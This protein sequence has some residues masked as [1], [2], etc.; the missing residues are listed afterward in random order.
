MSTDYWPSHSEARLNELREQLEYERTHDTLTGLEN[1]IQLLERLTIT[2]EHSWRQAVLLISIDNFRTVND[3]LGHAAGDRI[4]VEIAR[5]LEEVAGPGGGVARLAGDEFA[6]FVDA[7][8]EKNLLRLAQRLLQSLRQPLPAEDHALRLAAS[9]GIC[10]PQDGATAGTYLRDADTAMHVAKSHGAGQIRIFNPRMRA[11]IVDRFEIATSLGDALGTGTGL[12]LHFQPVVDL[13]TGALVGAE[14]L[15]RWD[16]PQRGMIPPDRFIRIAEE[17]G[18]IVDLGRWVLEAAVRQLADWMPLIGDREFR[19]HVNLSPVEIRQSG[20]VED[21][22]NILTTY[23]ADPAKM[24]VEITET[25]LMTNYE[26]S[27]EA[28]RGL[29]DAGLGIGIDDFGTGYSSISYLGQLPVDTVKLDRSLI[30]GIASS[31]FEYGLARAILELMHSAGLRVI[32]EGI[33]NQAQVAH[34]RAL[35]CRYGQGFHLARPAPAEATT[36]GLERD[37]ARF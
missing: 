33:E 2:L 30:S 16:H 13:E 12:L 17:T 28:L 11:E 5:R 3:T 18:L 20:L 23:G 34:L 36:A 4:L 25:E 27:L 19:V 24:L 22:S 26:T 31:P 6:M 29:R 21:V 37:A 7:S 32:A 9:V 15:V 1:R 10:L 8:S 14:A 35:D